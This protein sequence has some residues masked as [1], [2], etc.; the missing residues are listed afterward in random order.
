MKVTNPCDLVVIVTLYLLSVVLLVAV[1]GR[2]FVGSSSALLVDFRGV[3]ALS[4]NT[5]GTVAELGIRLDDIMIV[6]VDSY[7]R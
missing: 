6:V 1:A 2:I 5:T 7:S 3:G 4:F